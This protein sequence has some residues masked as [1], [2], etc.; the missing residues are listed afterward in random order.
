MSHWLEEA[1]NKVKSRRFKNSEI[2]TRV[3]TKKSDIIHNK[4]LIEDDF[5]DVIDQFI[6]I[7]QRIN[8]LPRHERIPFGQI[9]AKQ[10]ENKLDNLLHKFYSSRR[11]IVREFAGIFAPFKARHYKNSRSF[12]IS[13]GREEGSVLLEYKEIKAKRIRLNDQFKGFWS[14]LP[15]IKDTKENKEHHEVRES[16]TNTSIKMF[17]KELIM[18]HLDWLAFKTNGNQF[19]KT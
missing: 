7:I 14:F 19:F 5:L 16:I 6:S 1:E 15:F 4:E 10:K 12:F 8:N 11:L 18:D 2:K 3:K 9:I 13:I 17:T